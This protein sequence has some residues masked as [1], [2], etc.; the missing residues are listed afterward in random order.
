MSYQI[1]ETGFGFFVVDNRDQAISQSL[2]HTGDFETNQIALVLEFL[3]NKYSRDLKRNLF[4]DIGANIGTHTISAI[5]KYGFKRGLS[6]EPSKANFNILRTN[7]SLN[8]LCKKVKIV[9]S[10]AGIEESILELS[11]NSINFGDHRISSSSSIH[12]ET[13]QWQ[14]EGIFDG[15][16]RI[17]V[18][19]PVKFILEEVADYD[20]VDALCWIDT[21][22]Y[23]IPILTSLMPLHLNGLSSLIEF[24]PYGMECQG[25]SVENFLESVW[26]DNLEY[27]QMIVGD[28]NLFKPLTKDSIVSLWS[29]LRHSGDEEN[30]RYAF[31]SI[32]ISSKIHPSLMRRVIMTSKSQDSNSVPKVNN[33]GSIF[34]DNGKSIQLM[35][36]GLRLIEGCY[37]GDWMTEVIKRCRG[38]HEP[39]EEK[40]FHEVES[41]VP[42]DG[43]MVE[44]GCFWAYY[45]LWFLSKSRDRFAIGLEPEPRH[46]EF[47]RKNAKINNLDNQIM[48]VDGAC[49][50]GDNSIVNLITEQSGELNIKGYTVFDLLKLA[51]R[52]Y[53]D[54]LHCDTQGCEE[55]IVDQAIDLG[56]DSLLR[57]CF[58]STHAYEITGNPLT[59]QQ[60][61][62]KLKDAGVWILAEH[63]VYESFSGD[64]LIVASFEEVDRGMRVSLSSNRY[65]ENIFRHPS[66]HFCEA[67]KG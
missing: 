66:S 38:H 32:L 26:S 45:S 4:I 5:N 42:K 19:N 22:G 28:D 41:L 50:K 8:N 29:S 64:G 53:I 6:F 24:W 62:A 23:E 31:S 51:R 21:Q 30:G 36:N 27:H 40:V 12:S 47:G 25:Y 60:V 7:I 49:A 20:L 52:S 48:F 65:S 2:I 57:F 61:L 9:N 3:K 54:I 1:A 15:K 11:L 13:N 18:C 10:A 34:Q 37:Y 16:E 63:D 17:R 46:I 33:A 44:L 58:F 43:F 39:Q 35:H 55:F 14:D 67:I 59:H 56:K